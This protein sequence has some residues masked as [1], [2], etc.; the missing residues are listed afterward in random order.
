[1]TAD[2]RPTARHDLE[3]DLTSTQPETTSSTVPRTLPVNAN[4]RTDW[5][6]SSANLRSGDRAL[7]THNDPTGAAPLAI[8]TS[9]LV[10][11]LQNALLSGARRLIAARSD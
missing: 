2:T 8:G 4:R 1:M 10:Q 9:G 6:R 11:V 7:D 5:L 3:V